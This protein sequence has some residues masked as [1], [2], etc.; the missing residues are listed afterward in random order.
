[1][2]SDS[3][4]KLRASEERLE[5]G[6]DGLLEQIRDLERHRT[7]LETQLAVSQRQ[8]AEMRHTLDKVNTFS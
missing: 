6:R 7:E 3:V 8:E 4:G 2:L 5:E 1:M